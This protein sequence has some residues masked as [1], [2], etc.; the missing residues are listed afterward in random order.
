MPIQTIPRKGGVPPSLIGGA[1]QSGWRLR[2][3]VLHIVRHLVIIYSY[4]L[5]KIVKNE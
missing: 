5:D 1:G 4:N 3:V 2:I